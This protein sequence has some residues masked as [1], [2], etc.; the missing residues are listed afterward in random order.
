[1]GDPGTL[2]YAIQGYILGHHS[3]EHTGRQLELATELVALATR[4]GD[5][6]RVLEGHEERLDAFLEFGDMT[7]AKLEL[8]AMTRLARELHQPSQEWFAAIYRALLTLLTGNLSEA[9]EQISAAHRLGRRAQGWSAAVTYRLQLYALRREQ[10]RLA[11]VEDLVRR[12]A[13]EFPTY[14]IWRCVLAQLTAELG[15]GTEARAILEDPRG[16]PLRARALRRD[17]ARQHGAAR[18]HR[19]RAR[20][21][22]ARADPLRQA[23]PVR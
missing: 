7:A 17:V 3:P 19:H 8:E 4:V 18:G 9:E 22:G 15:D 20:R 2:V 6:E 11:D 21:R 16:G 5:K 10:G 12:S 13:E 14:P 23:A 1:M